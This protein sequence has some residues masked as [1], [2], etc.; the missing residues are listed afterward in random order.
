MEGKDVIIH[1]LERDFTEPIRDPLWKHIYLSPQLMSIVASAPFQKL[2]RI[3]QLGITHLVY[4]GATHTRFVHSLGVFHLAKRMVRGL[5]GSETAPS[6]TLEGVKAFLC[7]SLLHDIGHFPF[8][9]SLKELPLRDHES[10][11]AD[12]IFSPPLEPLL[13]EK[14][15]TEPW[16]VAAIVDN[17]IDDQG[18]PEID[19]FRNILS[20]L[21]DP[22]KLDYLN[23]DAYY[24]GVPY[25]IQDTDFIIN[26]IHPHPSRGIS[27]D[28]TGLPAAENVLFSKYLMY[29]SVY[30]HRTVRIA[31]AMIKKAVFLAL[32]DGMVSPEDLYGLDDEEF[33]HT[34]VEQS[35][36]PFSLIRRVVSRQLLK[37]VVEIPFDPSNPALEKLVDLEF[38]NQKEEE[39]A[40]ILSK[41]IGKPIEPED[42]VIDIPEDIS[43][44]IDLPILFPEGRFVQYSEAGSV[45]TP[46][47]VEGFVRTLRVLRLAVTPEILEYTP[48]E[49]LEGFLQT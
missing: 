48:G 33:F 27:L 10:L 4:P 18:F 7:A 44:E 20:G 14:V 9:H 13:K 45:F 35:Y 29:R 12:L 46:P 15:G 22:D 21:L 6:L 17:H 1:H 43:F 28:L 5:I 8:T 38:R 16:M 32:R 19:F 3:K 41:E 31:T 36:H 34:T 42:L 2:Y 25:G 24:C 11:T 30:W 37:A 39:A 47:V 26:R 23:R 40:W 49:I